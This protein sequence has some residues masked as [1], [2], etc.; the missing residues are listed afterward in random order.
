MATTTGKFAIILSS[1][2]DWY[3]WI[4]LVESEALKHKIWD[5]INPNTLDTALPKLTMP[6]EPTYSDVRPPTGNQPPTVYED[7]TEGQRSQFQYQLTRFLNTEKRFL[8]QEQALLDIRAR[9]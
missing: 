4:E 2:D 5:F 8:A 7:L 3:P 1:M 6:E 9:I